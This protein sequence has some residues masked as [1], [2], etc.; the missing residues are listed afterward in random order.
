MKLQRPRLM[1]VDDD[2]DCRQLLSTLLRDEFFVLTAE[3]GFEGYSRSLANR[4]DIVMLDM[5][6]PG[7]DGLRTLQAF[8]DNPKLRDIPILMLSADSKRDNVLAA[9]E[10]GA[11]GYVRKDS[12]SKASL[13]ERLRELVTVDEPR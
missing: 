12:F 9:V 4:P 13:H 3:E 10:A 2:P 5:Q 11:S 7:W 1:I 6:M 8:R